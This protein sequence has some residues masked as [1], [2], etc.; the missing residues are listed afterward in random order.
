M[1][2]LELAMAMVLNSR[3]G[4]ARAAQGQEYH[5]LPDG[6]VEDAVPPVLAQLLGKSAAFAVQ[7]NQAK[8]NT[9]ELDAAL[10]M[11]FIRDPIMA[12]A[13]GTYVQILGLDA[14]AGVKQGPLPVWI[15]PPKE[16]GYGPN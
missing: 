9:S 5:K 7:H 16:S 12:M 14:N 11:E 15:T 3:V 6:G 4:C 2:H 1:T 10:A 8:R 13:I